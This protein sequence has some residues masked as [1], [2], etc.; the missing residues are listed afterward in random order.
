VVLGIWTL[1]AV[2]PLWLGVI[3]QA[4]ATILFGLTVRHLWLVRQQQPI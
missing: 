4:G 1:L 2:V 3:H